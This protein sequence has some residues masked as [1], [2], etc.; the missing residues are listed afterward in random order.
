MPERL[1][2]APRDALAEAPERAVAAG[3]A[4]HRGDPDVV[5]AARHDPLERRRSL[6]TFT[7]SPYVRYPYR[8]PDQID[9]IFASPAQ[10]PVNGGSRTSAAIPWSA[11]TATIAF[12][13]VFTKSATARRP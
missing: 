9:A 10:T 6:S 7:A 11:S 2:K 8:D 1:G 5:D 12:S 4:S 3:L 13:I